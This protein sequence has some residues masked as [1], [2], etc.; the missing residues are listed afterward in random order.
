MRL[1]I[2]ATCA[3]APEMSV[4]FRTETNWEEQPARSAETPLWTP[5]YD[6]FSKG[7]Q[8]A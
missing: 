7:D 3:G 4:V 6:D 2:D 5:T 1:V 8:E